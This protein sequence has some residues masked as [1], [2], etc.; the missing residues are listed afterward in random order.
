[1]GGVCSISITLSSSVTASFGEPNRQLS[2]IAGARWIEL[3]RSF[4]KTS[5]MAD[6]AD[7]RLMEGKCFGLI[8]IYLPS[9]TCWRHTAKVFGTIFYCAWLHSNGQDASKHIHLLH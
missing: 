9:H 2:S 6:L 8:K 7:D 3:V 1:M 5:L 4:G